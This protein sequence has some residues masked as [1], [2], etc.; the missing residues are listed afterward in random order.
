V[1]YAMGIMA[2]GGPTASKPDPWNGSGQPRFSMIRIMFPA[3]SR[4]A[5]SRP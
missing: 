4:K 5:Q 1:R 3:G 2:V